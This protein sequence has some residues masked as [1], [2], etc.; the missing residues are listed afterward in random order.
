MK[1]ILSLSAVLITLYIVPSFASEVSIPQWSEFCPAQYQN[2]GSASFNTN[3]NYWHNRKMQFEN[4]IN[5]CKMKI[6]DEQSFCYSQVRERELLKNEILQ[7]RQ[8]REAPA[9][10][11]TQQTNSDIRFGTV[12]IMTG[13]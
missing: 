5:E 13:K 8:V 1:R 6:G 4:S 12:E 11:N 3:K 9:L 10:R 2:A 7:E